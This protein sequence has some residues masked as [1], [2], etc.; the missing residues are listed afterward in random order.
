[1]C[2]ALARRGPEEAEELMAFARQRGSLEWAAM[3]WRLSL[4]VESDPR[5]TARAMRGPVH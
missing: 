3:S 2:N 1:V 4:I 5:A